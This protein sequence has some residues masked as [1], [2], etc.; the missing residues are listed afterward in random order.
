MDQKGLGAILT[1]RP[2]GVP[3]CKGSVLLKTV[4]NPLQCAKFSAIEPGLQPFLSGMLSKQ[5]LPIATVAI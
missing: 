2:G 4:L 3:M 1:E 5:A